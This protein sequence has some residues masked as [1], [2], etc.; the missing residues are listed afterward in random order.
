M[1]YCLFKSDSAIRRWWGF[2]WV[3]DLFFYFF[4]FFFPLTDEDEEENTEDQDEQGNL[5]GLI[6]DGDEEEEEA[7]E[8]ADSDR[9]GSGG[10]SDSDDE[11]RHRR[12]KRSKCI[13]FSTSLNHCIFSVETSLIVID[14][15]TLFGNICLE[16][17]RLY[18][19]CL[20]RACINLSA[21]EKK[22]SSNPWFC[23]VDDPKP[24]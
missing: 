2:G 6:D 21:E 8:G 22:F 11:V 14:S 9:S 16:C 18:K 3:K 24:I 12:K 5:R 20:F 13:C 10:K 1:R 15:W 7:E 23:Y 4:L 19:L 17:K